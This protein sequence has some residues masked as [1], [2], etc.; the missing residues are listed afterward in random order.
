MLGG[1]QTS[2]TL[3]A[4]AG[5]LER[6]VM[7]RLDGGPH[8]LHDAAVCG[9]KEAPGRP[10]RLGC[11]ARRPPCTARRTALRD[12]PATGVDDGEMGHLTFWPRTAASRSAPFVASGS[13]L[14]RLCAARGCWDWPAS[15][16]PDSAISLF[17]GPQAKRTCSQR[18]EDHRDRNARHNVELTGRRRQDARPEPATMHRV[19]PARAWWPAV[20]APVERRVRRHSRR[21]DLISFHEP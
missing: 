15:A 9:C 19:P 10:A 20:G 8:A 11:P 21:S 4:V 7:P 13:C 5:R 2:L 16:G 17:G 3:P 6:G 18:C 12:T 1:P 14:R